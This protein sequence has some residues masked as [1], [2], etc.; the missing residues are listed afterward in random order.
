MTAR[1][2]LNA[3]LN[4]AID[5]ATDMLAA[6]TEFAPFAMA[7]QKE[8]GEIFHVEPEDEDD[9]ADD[10]VVIAALYA[11]L[12]EAVAEGRWKA[13]AVCADVTIEGDEGD[14]VSSAILVRMEHEADEPVA[15]MVSYDIGEETVELGDL[16]AEPGEAR[17]FVE[18]TPPN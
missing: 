2:D 6:D 4:A 16:H 3:L 9:G 8:D 17:V 5:V 15:C 7:I 18:A 12:K 1:E 14:A 11:G 10:E 13:I